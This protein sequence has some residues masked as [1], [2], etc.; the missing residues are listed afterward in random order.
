MY[1]HPVYSSF[2]HQVLLLEENGYLGYVDGLTE[3]RM[4]A[5]RLR[6]QFE[7]G[8][9]FLNT[10]QELQW[11]FVDAMLFLDAGTNRLPVQV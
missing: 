4:Y 10:I 11:D 9:I 7:Y 2:V 8:D 6:E 3:E 1:V 5:P